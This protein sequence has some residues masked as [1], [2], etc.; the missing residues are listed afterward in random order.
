MGSAYV[1]WIVQAV[2]AANWPSALRLWLV[3]SGC[4]S[5]G[6]GES[7]PSVESA[8]LWGM[9]RT[10]AQE[11][12]ELRATLVDL[13]ANPD[14]REARE[15]ARRIHENGDE[16]RM[17]LR[18]QQSYVARLALHGGEEVEATSLSAMRLI[19]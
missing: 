18:G 11:H 17:A 10:V 6:K 14:A 13:S 4:M 16:D 19:E 12:P 1:P 9:G 15:L 2:T 8:P 7:L 3:T 5:V